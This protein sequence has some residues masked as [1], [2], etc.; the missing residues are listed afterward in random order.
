MALETRI[1]VRLS[2]IEKENLQEQANDAGF[3]ISDY[4]RWLIVN[5]SG[6]EE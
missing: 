4:I 1:Q 5:N 2:E 3:T 6:K